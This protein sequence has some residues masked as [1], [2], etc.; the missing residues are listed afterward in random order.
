MLKTVECI[1]VG[2]YG[3]G[4][5]CMVYMYGMYGINVLYMEYHIPV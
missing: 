5:E 1:Y 2:V 3:Q 4:F